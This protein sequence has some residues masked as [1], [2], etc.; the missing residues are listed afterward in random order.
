MSFIIIILFL[1]FPATVSAAAK[2][3]LFMCIDSVIP[4]LFP[5]MTA[6]KCA[7]ISKD[8]PE[9]NII[10]RIISKIFKIPLCGA[11][12]F[13]FGLICGYPIGAKT[14]FDLLRE[15][16][17]SKEDAI[18]LSCFT[19]NAGP[20]FVI[21]VVGAGFLGSVTD[22]LIIYFSHIAGSIITGLFLRKYSRSQIQSVKRE[23]SLS[24]FDAIPSAIAD[25]STG[26]LNVTATIMFFSSV[27]AVIK[28][29]LP[30][31][32]INTPLK[33][34]LLSGFFE[35]T[36]G[37]KILSS[38]N[39]PKTVLLPLITFLTGFSGISVIFQTKSFARGLNIKTTPCII[40][41][42]LSSVLSF[43]ICYFLTIAILFLARES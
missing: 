20:A 31:Y 36:S 2:D 26:V 34:G 42:V 37:I 40:C 18:R 30:P 33:E 19:N 27:F 8:I 14:A 28:T 6:A 12:S 15:K 35:I 29:L 25:S 3:A 22:G 41:K 23:K 32:V 16:R 4:A 39:L 11:F 13:V 43:I 1:A 17:I 38:A 5:F 7:V 9:D 21:A 24:L 10:F